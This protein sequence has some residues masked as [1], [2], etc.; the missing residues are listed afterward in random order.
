M[1]YSEP[2]NAAAGSRMKAR[3]TGIKRGV[4]HL[5]SPIPSIPVKPNTLTSFTF[6]SVLSTKTSNQKRFSINHGIESHSWATETCL[7]IQQL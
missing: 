6:N 1:H 3:N 7:M 4:L 2:A 5:K